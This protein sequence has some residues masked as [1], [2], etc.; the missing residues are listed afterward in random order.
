MIL[1]GVLGPEGT[2]SENAAKLWLSSGVD[3]QLNYYD[4]IS[5]IFDGVLRGEADYGVVPIENSLEGSV[6]ETL[7]LL[8]KE[9]VKIVAEVLVPIRICLLARG[10]LSDVKIIMSHPHALAQCRGFL[11]KLKG[12]VEVRETGSTAHAAKLAE[13]FKEVAAL[14]SEDSASKYDLRVLA[15]DVQDRNSITRFIVIAREGAEDSKP[16]GNDKTSIIL[17]LKDRPGALYEVLGEFAKRKINLT[18]IE[19]RPSK[20]A[21]GDYMFH[22]DCEGHVRDKK[23]KEALLCINEKAETLKV[24]GSYPKATQG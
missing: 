16:T 20:R 13:E 4:T 18:K 3:F 2:F 9:P 17:Y 8:S 11:R 22:I 15:R 24:L 6:G 21:L 10:E 7:D 14:A 1:V 12:K 5:D 23:V 19:S